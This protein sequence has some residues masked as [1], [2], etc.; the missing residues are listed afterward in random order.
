MAQ[1]VS[2]HYIFSEQTHGGGNFGYRRTIDDQAVL[3]MQHRV[4]TATI[5][6]GNHW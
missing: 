4:C 1:A 6:T 5:T 3:A 2:Q